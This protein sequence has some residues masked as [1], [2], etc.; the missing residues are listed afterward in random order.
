MSKTKKV[1]RPK[2]W[3]KGSQKPL[4]LGPIPM[5]LHSEIK[6]FARHKKAQL[7]ELM[8]LQNQKAQEV[9]NG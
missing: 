5:Q 7:L 6:E 8:E 1:G 3:P 2:V 9:T 4:N